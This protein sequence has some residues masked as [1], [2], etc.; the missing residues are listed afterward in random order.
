MLKDK[1]YTNHPHTED[2]VRENIHNVFSV[3]LAELCAINGVFVRCDSVSAD[4]NNFQLLLY[5]WLVKLIL[6]AIY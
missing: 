4:G 5:K 6:I 2:N 1:M 3:S